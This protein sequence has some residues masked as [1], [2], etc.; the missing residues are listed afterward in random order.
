MFPS[1]RGDQSPEPDQ[2]DT[3]T[4]FPVGGLSS[5]HPGRGVDVS[6][7]LLAGASSPWM[8]GGPRRFLQTFLGFGVEG[9]T[10]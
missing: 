8:V 9:T 10:V 5:R 3:Q 2:G 4:A 7:S 1:H 6:R